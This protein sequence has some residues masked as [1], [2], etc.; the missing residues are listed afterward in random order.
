MNEVNTLETRKE[1]EGNNGRWNVET[2]KGKGFLMLIC[3]SIKNWK[4]QQRI[5][6][7]RRIQ[8]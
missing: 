7:L 8:L 5:T 3:S 2:E 4:P 6:E 1:Y